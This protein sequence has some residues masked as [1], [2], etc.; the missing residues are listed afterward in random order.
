MGKT[1]SKLTIIFIAI[2]FLAGCTE[3]NAPQLSSE[4]PTRTNHDL[5]RVG[6][7][8]VYNIEQD[9]KTGCMYLEYDSVQERGLSPYYDETGKVK[10][11]FASE[12]AVPSGANPEVEED[13]LEES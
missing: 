10:G 5:V 2:L 3:S 7:I 9:N 4:E 13:V 1:F 11:C 6:S 12:G 8:G